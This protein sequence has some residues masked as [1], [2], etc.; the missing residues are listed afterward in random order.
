MGDVAPCK[1][2]S[3]WISKHTP[4]TLT[5]PKRLISGNVNEKSEHNEMKKSDG[6]CVCVCVHNVSVI[7]I[8]F[9]HGVILSVLRSHVVVFG[10]VHL[11]VLVLAF[12]PST[13]VVA[14]KRFINDNSAPTFKYIFFFAMNFNSKISFQSISVFFFLNPAKNHYLFDFP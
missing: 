3:V 10:C 2:Q 5:L 1:I 12:I 4:C 11:S 6:L 7:F 9:T 13:I 8:E 14:T